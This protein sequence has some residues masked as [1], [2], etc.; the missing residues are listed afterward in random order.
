MDAKLKKEF[1]DMLEDMTDLETKYAV[2]SV[3]DKYVTLMI[4]TVQLL[5]TDGTDWKLIE[6]RGSGGFS[7]P[8]TIVPKEGEPVGQLYNLGT[9]PTEKNNLY[10]ENPKVVNELLKELNTIRN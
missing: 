2:D 3:Q 6:K 1:N 7:N 8:V 9:D 10:N 4:S 5:M